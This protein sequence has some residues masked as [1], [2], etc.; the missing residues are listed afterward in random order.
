MKRNLDHL[1]KDVYGKPFKDDL[2]LG[3]AMA[4]ALVAQLPED[5]KQTLEERIKQYRLLQRVVAGGVQE[6]T[7][8][9]L[10]LVKKRGAAVFQ[11]TGVG[12]VADALDKD[13]VALVVVDGGEGAPKEEK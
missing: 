6:F 12:A 7:S 4:M 5:Q 13:Y 10:S 1:L 11:L 9:E 2:T 3:G 8:D